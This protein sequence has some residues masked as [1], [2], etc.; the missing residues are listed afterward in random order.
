MTDTVVKTYRK[1]PVENQAVQFTGENWAEMHEF[2]GHFTPVG[3]DIPMDVFLD[4]PTPVGDLVARLWVAANQQW[5][6]IEIGEW[7]IQDKLGFYPCKNSVFQETHTEVTDDIEPETGV[8][9]EPTE[10]GFYYGEGARQSMIFL[11]D[12]HGQWYA[13]IDNSMMEKCAWGYIEQSTGV[14]PLRRVGE[15]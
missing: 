14:F 4:Y 12:H 13:I 15:S 9:E 7:V 10:P 3:R 11:L 5:L 2:T 8:S 6:G 1:N